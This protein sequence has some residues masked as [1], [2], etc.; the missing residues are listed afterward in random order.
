MS[1]KKLQQENLKNSIFIF[2]TNNAPFT[3]REINHTFIL[4]LQS[5]I[6]SLNLSDQMLLKQSEDLL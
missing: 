4:F 3:N 5:F 1:P 6:S 2:G